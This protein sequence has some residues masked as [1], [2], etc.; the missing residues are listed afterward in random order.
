MVV[1]VYALRLRQNL[2][3]KFHRKNVHLKSHVDSIGTPN[4]S[5]NL[6]YDV[7]YFSGCEFHFKAAGCSCVKRNK[8]THAHTLTLCI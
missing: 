5:R 1:V 3:D 7:H 2:S 6:L 4:A 8:T